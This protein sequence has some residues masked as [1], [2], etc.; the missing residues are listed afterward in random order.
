VAEVLGDV[1]GAGYD[2]A[3]PRFAVITAP[4]HQRDM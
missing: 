1:A 4:R 2:P 3:A